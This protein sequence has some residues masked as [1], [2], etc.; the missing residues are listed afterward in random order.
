MLDVSV[1]TW[2]R[3]V[4]DGRVPVVRLRGRGSPPFNRDEI[5]AI[6]SGRAR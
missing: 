4:H 6:I 1:V 3:A 5:N 2:R